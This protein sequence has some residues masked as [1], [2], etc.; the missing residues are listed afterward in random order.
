MSTMVYVAVALLRSGK[1]GTTRY[2]RCPPVRLPSSVPRLGVWLWPF[3]V[4]T[5]DETCLICLTFGIFLYFIRLHSVKALQADHAVRGEKQS[6][7][8]LARISALLAEPPTNLRR[9]QGAGEDCDSAFMDCLKNDGCVDCFVELETKEIDW[10]TVSAETPCGDVTKILFKEGHC[11][12]MENNVDALAIFCETFDTCVAFE[13]E[14][15]NNS[16]SLVNCNAL[17]T[18]DWEGK[19]DQFLGDGI[20]HEGIGCYNSEGEYQ[21]GSR[22]RSGSMHRQL[23]HFD[24]STSLR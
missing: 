15:N 24:S 19:H 11:K 7:I 23:M 18:C 12:R 17:K 6:V 20:C 14:E 10:A 4:A 16:D 3:S 2:N 22:K 9:L 8:D 5:C 21:K 13:D 1:D